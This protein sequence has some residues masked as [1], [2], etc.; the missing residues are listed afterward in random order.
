MKPLIDYAERIGIDENVVEYNISLKTRTWIHRGGEAKVW[1][2]PNSY[3]DLL[4]ICRYLYL[5][6]LSFD[7]IGHTS[8]IYFLNSYNPSFV[9]DTK[10][11]KK[12]KFT[13]S[14][15]ICDVGFPMMKLA[16][17]CIKRGIKGYEG[18]INLPGTVAGAVVNNSGCF[19]CEICDVVNKVEILLPNGDIEELTKATKNFEDVQNLTFYAPLIS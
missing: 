5:E 16:K 1:F 3:E 17:E 4:K 9:I 19:G 18:F 12:I 7:I 13:D 2:T 10:K 14:E 11:I 15:V 6:N 8:N